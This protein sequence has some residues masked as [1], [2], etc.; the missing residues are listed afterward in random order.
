M[1]PFIISLTLSLFYKTLS[2]KAEHLKFAD[3][4]TFDLTINLTRKKARL[5]ANIYIYVNNGLGL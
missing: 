5:D 3:M 4:R 1:H 2:L